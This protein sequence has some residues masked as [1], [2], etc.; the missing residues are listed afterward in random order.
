MSRIRQISNEII[1]PVM[2]K[3][4][5]TL[6]RRIKG[7]AGSLRPDER[8][9]KA[10]AA[11]KGNPKSLGYVVGDPIVTVPV[12][13]VR[14]PDGRGYTPDEHHFLKY[15]EA[16][17]D[18]L[19]SFYDSH[20]P[21]NVFEFFGIEASETV[22]VEGYDPPWFD[23][24]ASVGKSGEKGLTPDDGN[25]AF[26]PVSERKLRL[27]AA[28][29]DHVLS[30]IQ[31]QGFRP[32]IGGHVRGYFMHRTN[33]EWVFVVREGF[34]RTAALVQLG[35]DEIDVRFVRGYPRFVEETDSAE[36]PLVKNALVTERAALA[37]FSRFFDEKR[38]H[39][40]D[41]KNI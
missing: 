30:S 32:E 3:S 33:G 36:W 4:V 6:W 17:L 16:G 39:S 29:L 40:L 24:T 13:R 22:N 37:M 5:S 7:D 20:Q 1:P 10:I 2:K 11:P 28:R 19:R 15:Y 23:H 21:Q 41:L 26:G 27:E 9:P 12:E 25:Q 14:Y 31:T 38:D 35:F 34:H 8:F 18:S